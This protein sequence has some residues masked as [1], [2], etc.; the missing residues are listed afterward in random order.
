[1]VRNC[2]AVSK[3]ICFQT[4][5]LFEWRWTYVTNICELQQVP[6]SACQTSVILDFHNI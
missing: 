3:N 4:E 2:L 6:I 5:A 1:M